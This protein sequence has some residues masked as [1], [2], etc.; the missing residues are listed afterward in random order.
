MKLLPANHDRVNALIAVGVWLAALIVYARTLAPTLSLWDCGEFIAASYILGI[1]HPPGTPTYIMLGRIATLIPTFTDICARVNFLSAFCSSLAA[2]FSYLFGVRIL[3]YW[4]T[5]KPSCYSRILTYGGAASGA[6]FLAFSRTQWGNSIEA[7]VYGMSMLL[8]FAIAWLTLIYLE[9]RG[10]LLGNK[11]MLLV[12]YLGFLGIGVHMATFLVLPISAVV[13]ILKKDTPHKYWFLIASFF[14]IELFLIFALSSRPG[15]VPYYFPIFLVGLFYLF[16]MLSFE[17]IAWQLLAVA[18]GFL[19]SCLPAMAALAG[20]SGAIWTTV[21]LVGYVGLLGFGLFLITDHIKKTRASETVARGSLTAGIFVVVSA[22]MTALTQAGLDNGPDGYGTF[23]FI[24]VA[25]AV[26]I[27]VLIWRYINLPV[28]VALIGPAMIMLGVREFSWGTVVALVMVLVMG[29]VFK[30]AGWR[31]A[32]LIIIMAVAGYST[33]LFAPIRSSQDPYIN[34][35]NPSDSL[36]ATINFFERKQYGSQSMTERMFVRRGEWDNQFG[37]HRRM[38]FYYFFNEQYGFSGRSFV[39]ILLLGVFGAW[40]AC[41]RRPEAGLYLTLLMLVSSVGLVLYMNFADGTRQTAYDAWL[42]VR[43]RDYFFTPAF[44]FF[45][46]AIGLGISAAIQLLRDLTLKFSNV[47]RRVVLSSVLV[48]FLLPVYAV[49]GNY[50]YCDRSNNYIPYDY[51]WNILESCDQDA[52]LFTYGDNDTF[53]LWC[54]QE[55]YGIRRDVKSICCSLANGIWYVK[56]VRNYMGVD[57]GWTDQQIAELRPFRTKDGRP[58]RIQDQVV[59]AVSTRNLGKRPINFSLLATSSARRLYGIRVDSLMEMNGLV[60]RLTDSVT[61]GALRI[62]TDLNIDLLIGSGRMKYRGWTDPELYRCETT[63]RSIAGVSDRFMAVAEALLRERRVD[64]AARVM[65]FVVDSVY[66]SSQAVQA[67]AAVLAEAGDTGRLTDLVAQHPEADSLELMT[68]LARGY[69]R[70]NDLSRA[71]A[72]LL[73]LL[74]AYPN[75][76]G[77]LDEL[78]QIYIAERDIEAMILVLETWVQNNPGDADVREALRE[79]EKQ[80]EEVRN[81]T[82]DSS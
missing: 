74:I 11:V 79:L 5:D 60:Y 53:P 77:A 66:S 56:Q 35:N 47:P 14:A 52:I 58:F 69:Y 38:G 61:T 28:L 15:E 50:Y 64:E 72:V 9:N 80:V 62:G 1:P 24:T 26:V 43:D 25:L 16:F 54:L 51:A 68:L 78:M 22:L 7:E 12:A 34:M 49:A 81:Q 71:S 41:R 21:G 73:Q 33:H 10:T 20:F 8:V 19:V 32:L 13:F 29:L 46:L 37:D 3:R 30:V 31:I 23:L 75:N 63:R 39:I 36:T 40:E 45:G 70:A 27:G 18:G 4:F 55:V 59:D 17:R 48:V 67:L 6:L 65:Q 2:M 44:M 57:L 42:E 82:G 76:R